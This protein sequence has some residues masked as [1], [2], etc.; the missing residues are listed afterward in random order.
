MK[1][2]IVGFDVAVL[3]KEKGFDIPQRDFYPQQD[4]ADKTLLH[5]IYTGHQEFIKPFD[6][7]VG[8]G[9]I[10]LA[11]TQSLLQK[12]LR[13]V[14]GIFCMPDVAFRD[15]ESELIHYTVSVYKTF[16]EKLSIMM[17][18]LEEEIEYFPTYEQAL[19]TGLLKALELI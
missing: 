13:E 2:T 12:W 19:E 8:F 15:T 7:E 11:P 10:I 3:A 17:D 9:D 14:H 16:D 6:E 18:E 4:W 5:A 1:D